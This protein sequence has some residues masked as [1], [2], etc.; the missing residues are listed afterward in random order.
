LGKGLASVVKVGDVTDEFG[1][2]ADGLGDYSADG[3]GTGRDKD[4]SGDGLTLGDAMDRG[5]PSLESDGGEAALGRN[6]GA[7]DKSRAAGDGS[8]DS[9]EGRHVE[10]SQ[11]L[12]WRRIR[13]LE[14]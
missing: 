13:R 12:S 5:I 14:L 6:Y 7:V 11:T 2:G 3:S 4:G 10:K 8:D 9:G 1:S